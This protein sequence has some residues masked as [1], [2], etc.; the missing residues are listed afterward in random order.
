MKK[1]SNYWEIAATELQA[2]NKA[3][4]INLLNAQRESDRRLDAL[5]RCRGHLEIGVP[6]IAL[7]YLK[8]DLSSMEPMFTRNG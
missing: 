1:M 7:E 3:L 2:E 5:K 6:I 4:R 8:D